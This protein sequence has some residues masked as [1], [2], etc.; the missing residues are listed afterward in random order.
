[1]LYDLNK[2]Q[3]DHLPHQRE[4]DDWRRR[5]PDADYSAI[6]DEL[7]RHFDLVYD[8]QQDR[9][10][11]ASFL[12]G[13]DWTGTVFQPIYHAT[14]NLKEHAALF[15]GQIVWEAIRSHHGDWLFLRQERNDDRPIG[16]TYFVWEH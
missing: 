16:L 5:L 4:F 1:M 12:P 10:F 13:S 11:N 9:V 15:F 14:G 7:Y 8:R 2:Q 3:I 6:V